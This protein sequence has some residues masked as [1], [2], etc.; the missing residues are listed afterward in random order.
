MGVIPPADDHEGGSRHLFEKTIAVIEM[1]SA[2]DDST[3]FIRMFHGGDHGGI[4]SVTDP[5]EAYPKFFGS[6]LAP[7]P[8]KDRG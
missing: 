7:Q 6:W 1:T 8:V 4:G 2:G 5:E 3:H